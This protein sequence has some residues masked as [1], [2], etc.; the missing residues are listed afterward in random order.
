M[1]ERSKVVLVFPTTKGGPITIT[2]YDYGRLN[3]ENY[4]NDVIIDFYLK[5]LVER[6]IADASRFHVFGSYLF[7]CLNVNSSNPYDRV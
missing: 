3:P 6:G 7:S 1:D 2:E 5:F 4:I